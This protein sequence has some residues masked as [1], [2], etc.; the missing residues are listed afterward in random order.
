MNKSSPLNHCDFHSLIDLADID[1]L[2]GML[3][4]LLVLACSQWASRTEG[5]D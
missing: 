3:A 1:E 5:G 2:V 4:S